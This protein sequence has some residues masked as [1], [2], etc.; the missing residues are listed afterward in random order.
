ML[1]PRLGTARVQETRPVFPSPIMETPKC[2]LK[3]CLY[4]DNSDNYTKLTATRG[5]LASY[6]IRPT[7]WSNRWGN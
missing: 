1:S 4:L 7:H 2:F 3:A 5:I 6:I